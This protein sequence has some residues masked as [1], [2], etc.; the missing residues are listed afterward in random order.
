M[1]AWDN[2]ICSCSIFA[3][4]N[5]QCRIVGAA[6]A[7]VAADTDCCHGKTTTT[8]PSSKGENGVFG[9]SPKDLILVTV[10]DHNFAEPAAAVVPPWSSS[11]EIFASRNVEY[12]VLQVQV[13]LPNAALASLDSHVDG[14]F[15]WIL[16]SRNDGKDGVGAH[17]HCHCCSS[18]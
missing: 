9:T 1:L 7:A 4:D 5:Q 2:W 18:P 11:L 8:N 15:P 14:K 6:A 10:A 13:N 16:E 17:R 12:D 3:H